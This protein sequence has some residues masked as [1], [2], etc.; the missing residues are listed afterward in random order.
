M[1]R[2]RVIPVLGI[3][4][5]KMVKTIQF[6]KPKYL[7]DPINAIKIFNEK[8][9]DEICILD[10]RAS[11]KNREPDYDHI[12]E[13]AGEAFMPMA[14]GGGVSTFEQAKKVFACGVEKVILNSAFVKNPSLFNEIAQTY[15]EQSVVLSLDVAKNWRGE[16]VTKWNSGSKKGE[17]LKNFMQTMNDISVGEVLLHNIEREGTFK[18]IDLALVQQVATQTNVPVVGVGGV[19]S[20]QNMLEAAKSGASAIA[21][22]SYFSFKNNNTDSILINYPNQEVLKEKIFLNLPEK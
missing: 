3:E 12:F 14:Y 7:G 17:K 5:R 4:S 22:A 18:G 21:A 9:V 11:I 20:L 8:E 1:R 16:W 13:M 6:K 2:I 19:N 15:G 10:I